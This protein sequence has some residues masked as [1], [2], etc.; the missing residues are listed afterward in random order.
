M[1]ILEEIWPNFFIVGGARCGTTSL[2]SYLKAVPKI[3]MSDWKAPNYF[4]PNPTINRENYLKLFRDGKDKDVRGES[5]GY[6][7]EI[8]SPELIHKQVSDAKIII[9]LRDPV[10]RT[11]SHFLQGLGGNYYVGTFEDAFRIYQ[12]NNIEEELYKVMKHMI[13]CSFYSERVEKFLKT[14]GK[15]QVKVIIFEEYSSDVKKY[16]KEI[17]EFLNVD[18]D[19]PTNVNKAYNPY[20]Q[21]LGKIGRAIVQNPTL[22]GVAKSIFPGDSARNILRVTTGKKG[23]KPKLGTYERKEL[24]KIFRQDVENLKNVLGRTFPWSIS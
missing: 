4:I 21:P 15:K 5:S 16:V 11:F 20:R 24:E 17:L 9:S 10:E 6:L 19:I 14:F 12:E 2:Y 3:F 18:E 23:K 8:Q 22:K 13:D 7:Y 1:E